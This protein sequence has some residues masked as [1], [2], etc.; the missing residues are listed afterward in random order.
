MVSY[1]SGKTLKRKIKLLD[2]SPKL[3]KKS[4]NPKN[5]MV[6]VQLRRGVDHMNLGPIEP[7]LVREGPD[8]RK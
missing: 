2:K 3:L 4:L 7:F 5:N 6:M 8:Q 1:K